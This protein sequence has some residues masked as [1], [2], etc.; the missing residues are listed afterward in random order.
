[1][2]GQQEGGRWPAEGL[3]DHKASPSGG[4]GAHR[5]TSS[6][7]VACSLMPTLPASPLQLFLPSGPFTG[8]ED[9]VSS[10]SSTPLLVSYQVSQAPSLPLPIPP[11]D[12]GGPLTQAPAVCGPWAGLEAW[13]AH[14]TGGETEV[15]GRHHARRGDLSLLPQ[16]TGLAGGPG[17]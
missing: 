8:L 15:P 7:P 9:P 13:S 1:M 2:G 14:Y 10:L 17:S 5:G 6:L 11:G 16:V 12:Q 3:E 4:R